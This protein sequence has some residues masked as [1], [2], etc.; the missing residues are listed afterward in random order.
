MHIEMLKKMGF[1]LSIS[2]LLLSSLIAFYCCGNSGGI[3]RV[4]AIGYT[5]TEPD[6][7]IILPGILREISGLTVLDSSTVACIQDEK[8]V[9]YIFDV[10]NDEIRK[11]ISFNSGGDYEAICRVDQ[12]IYVLRSDGVLFIIS[13][14]E[15]SSFPEK[16]KLNGIS[17]ADNEGLCY[18]QG[19]RRLLIAPKSKPEKGSGFKGDHI[20]YGFDLSSQSLIK[21]PVIEIDLTAVRR[22]LAI[23]EDI[24]L[25]KNKKK[26]KK[27][28]PEINFKPSD[29]CIHPVTHKLYVLSGEERTLYV[30]NTD[31]TI[32]YAE[33]LDPYIFN[34]PEG[35]A[36]FKNGDMLISNEAGNR[37]PTILR[38]NYKFK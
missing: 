18:D 8:G 4:N 25:K 26:D 6:K 28:L 3:K 22:F 34:M 5:L 23:K 24:R 27:Y 15:S 11:E 10:L 30:F 13:N 20:I 35:I 36:F 33:K 38:F 29:I 9:I 12:T 2:V 17:T 21:E 31:G 37:Y 14:Y 7:T 1:R 16:I 32:E 19:N